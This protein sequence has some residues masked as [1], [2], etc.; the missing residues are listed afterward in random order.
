MARAAERIAF[1]AVDQKHP[2]LPS[3]ALSLKC[4]ERRRHGSLEWDQTFY[5]PI[6]VSLDELQHGSLVV[7]LDL[8]GIK[9]GSGL[10]GLGIGS[11]KRGQSGHGILT[12]DAYDSYKDD[13][14]VVAITQ[15][16]LKKVVDAGKE[17]LSEK[18]TL[19]QPLQESGKFWAG[20]RKVANIGNVKVKFAWF[21]V[22]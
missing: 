9:S 11:W 3:P 22:S 5:L 14:E 2:D 8:G 13:V 15:Y 7:Q 12:L 19:S 21:S 6:S 18:L 17:G 1:P 16:E 10:F 20:G 4:R